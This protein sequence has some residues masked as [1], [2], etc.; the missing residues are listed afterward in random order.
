MPTGVRGA[1][2]LTGVEA[3]ALAIGCV[4]YLR[5]GLAGN[6]GDRGTALL[7]GAMGLA[8]AGLLAVLARGLARRRRPAL[9]PVVLT[10]IFLLPVGW[11]LFRTGQVLIALVLV[12]LS[13]AVLGLLFG[14]AEARDA[15]S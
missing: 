7:G 2:V 3:A 9:A 1:A 5:A 15:F 6:P 4:L 11:N 12:G 8:L 14:T 10:Q 13:L